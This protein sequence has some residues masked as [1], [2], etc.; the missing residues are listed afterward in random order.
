MPITFRR[1]V[2][3]NHG[4]LLVN[5]PKEIV[6]ALELRKGDTLAIVWN[7]GSFTCKKEDL[8]D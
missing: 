4:S 6:E 8:M 1:K 7:N 2:L 3:S 5:I